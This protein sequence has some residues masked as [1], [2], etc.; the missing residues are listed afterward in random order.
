M[1]IIQIPWIL[2]LS[3]AILLM[4]IEIISP[5][6]LFGLFSAGAFITA[7]FAFFFPGLI[8]IQILIFAVASL[9]FIIFVRR[10]IMDYFTDEEHRKMKTN[11]ES[12]IGSRFR[13]ITDADEEGGSV[14]VGDVV[15][16]VRT[17]GESIKE[18]SYV[19]VKRIEGNK[20]IVESEDE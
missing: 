6:F 2:W 8:Y 18:G 7:V 3:F 9:I 16:R 1:N 5:L 12:L 15:W 17:E 14:K 19:T 20:L 11:A 4:I 13:L 10:I